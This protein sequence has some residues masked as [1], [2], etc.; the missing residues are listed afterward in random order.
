MKSLLA[1]QKE[2]L[3]RK[4]AALTGL[5]SP[6]ILA[7]MSRPKNPEHGDLAFPAFLL[8]KPWG[9]PPPKCAERLCREL[10]LPEA[11]E[12]AVAAG[13]FANFKFRRGPFTK[14]AVE[15]VFGES[16]SVWPKRSEGP[17]VIDYSSPNIAKP[18]HVGHLRATL[19]GHSLDLVYRKLGYTVISVNHL[20]DWGTQFG[21]VWAGCQLWGKPEAPTVKELV[22]LYKKA[23]QLK[24]EEEKNITPVPAD[25]PSVN[26]IARK[27]FSDLEAGEKYAKEFWQWCLDVSLAYFKTTY[28]RLGI[29][30]DHYMG[31]SFY[32]DK[33][34]FV[35]EVL[36]RSGLLIESQGAFGID[37]GEKGGFARVLT[38]D[39]RS[40]YL[41]RDIATAFY[42]AENFHFSKAIYVVGT[43][44]TLHFQQLKGV[45]AALG[46]RYSDD[47]LHV[48]FGLVIGMKT[49]GE[50]EVIELNDLLDEAVERAHTAY[51][52]QVEKRPEGLDDAVVAEAV[53]L[54]AIIFSSLNRSRIK[55]VQ[56]SWEQALA[57]QGDSGP[58][59]LYAFARINGIKEKAEASGLRFASKLSDTDLPEEGAFQLALLLDEFELMVE[60]TAADNEPSHLSA[61]A[62]DLAKAL[63]R[64][65]LDLKVI[66]AEKNI[67]EARLA[68]FEATALVLK[69]TLALLGMKTVERM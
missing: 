18:F 62:L 58:Y 68:L 37:L 39:G 17:V 40:L 55:D 7:A 34:N 61:Y 66:G 48:P 10:Q 36:E 41:T 32:S 69:E 3:S 65:Y 22:Q 44:Q 50:G 16:F 12:S 56:F 43:P 4:I 42:R 20:G 59:A 28:A 67:A 9:A 54:G 1:G 6:A 15:K 53:G 60:R 52:E 46:K 57:F 21:F 45:L 33:L 25:R 5:D 30:F 13:P 26:E 49:R 24:D 38:P 19:V 35:R 31:E 51:R 11:F 23:T 63:S 47:M 27:Y 64:A 2:E 8:A 29:V 14:L